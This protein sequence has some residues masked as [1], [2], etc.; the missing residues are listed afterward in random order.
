MDRCIETPLVLNIVVCKD[1][2]HRLKPH[3]CLG[4]EQINAHKAETGLPKF[5][6]AEAGSFLPQNPV[7]NDRCW[8]H[9]VLRR[10]W[11]PRP[12]LQNAG[13][14]PVWPHLCMSPP[15]SGFPRQIPCRNPAKRPA[16]GPPSFFKTVQWGSLV[17][18]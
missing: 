8:N 2:G 7:E 13:V 12:T 18:I 17:L 11:P 4:A 10:S 6:V 3:G 16:L 5:Q 1:A 9:S 14:E 15:P